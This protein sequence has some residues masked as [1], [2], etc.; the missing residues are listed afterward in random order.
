M[1]GKRK[2]NSLIILAAKKKKNIPFFRNFEP[3]QKDKQLHH[4][5]KSLMKV[6]EYK[7]LKRG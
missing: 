1:K 4:T 7:I 2:L 5:C 3:I 6:L